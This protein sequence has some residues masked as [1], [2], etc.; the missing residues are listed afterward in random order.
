MHN[1]GKFE[2]LLQNLNDIHALS[3]QFWVIMMFIFADILS[4]I[5]HYYEEKL[6]L[7]CKGVF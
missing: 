4:C 2:H 6:L 5:A 7:S 3:I 1:L